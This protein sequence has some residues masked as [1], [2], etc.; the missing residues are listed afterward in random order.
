MGGFGG[1]VVS[2]TRDLHK[3]EAKIQQIQIDNIDSSGCKLYQDLNELRKL[4]RS[5]I[6][7][8]NRRKELLKFDTST[9]YV[10]LDGVNRS[11]DEL[12]KRES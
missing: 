7:E 11:M 10:C 9:R 1:G 2:F 6:I 5:E 3:I 8:S 12:K 4:I